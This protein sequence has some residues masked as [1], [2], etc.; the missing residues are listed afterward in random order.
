MPSEYMNMLFSLIF[1]YLAD[2]KKKDSIYGSCTIEKEEEEDGREKEED[3]EDKNL[4]ELQ[5]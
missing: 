2:W 1:L 3:L 4:K 5:N